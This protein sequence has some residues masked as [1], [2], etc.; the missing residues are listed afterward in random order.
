MAGQQHASLYVPSLA[1]RVQ[2]VTSS[3]DVLGDSLEP[4]RSRK[5]AHAASRRACQE[6][7]AQG[8]QERVGRS[9]QDV[10]E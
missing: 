4:R 8:V 5:D 2:R 1:A 6:R 7:R 3:L 9:R 10:E